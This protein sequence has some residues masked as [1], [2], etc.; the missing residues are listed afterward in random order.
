MIAHP[1]AQIHKCNRFYLI[2]Y[3]H[4]DSA[5][6]CLQWSGTEGRKYD[7]IHSHGPVPL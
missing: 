1:G 2:D 7:L 5:S 4:S 6:F 3:F